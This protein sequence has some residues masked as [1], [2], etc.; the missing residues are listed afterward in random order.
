MA[1]GKLETILPPRA[2]QLPENHIAE[3]IPAAPVL[4]ALQLTAKQQL[5]QDEF[6]KWFKV[7]ENTPN[8]FRVFGYAGTGKTT[9]T[10]AIVSKVEETF[11]MSVM[12]GAYTGKATLVMG[13]NGMPA[14]TIHSTIYKVLTPDKNVVNLLRKQMKD[15]ED[16]NEKAALGKQ[17]EKAEAIGFELNEDSKLAD[18]GLYVLDECS[19]VNDEI[20]RDIQSFEVPLLVLGDPG[21][22]PPIDGTGALVRDKPN[23]FLDEIMRQAL[24]NP[25]IKMSILARGGARIPLGDM[26]KARHVSQRSLTSAE[27]LQADQILVG[28]NNTRLALNKRMRDLHGRAGRYPIPGDKLIC[29]RN[30]KELG[31]FNGLN[32]TVIRVLDEYATTIQYELLDELGKT[33]T[34]KILRCYFDEYYTPGVIKEL[35]WWDLQEGQAFDFGYAITVHKSQGSQWDNVVLFDDN[36]FVWDKPQRAKWLYTA[37]TRAA[38][39]FTL[40]S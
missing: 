7:N 31:L 11:K 38:D 16:K 34:C 23:V 2:D 40:A 37:I 39:S 35:K 28:K 18:A 17:L 9:A 3:V 13:K 32:A 20:L 5:A 36:F 8:I 1:I 33:I 12:Y 15:A 10:K 26:G 6:L 14:S 19:M 22:L 24:D 27:M 21:Q 25:I 4:P 29:L 30:N